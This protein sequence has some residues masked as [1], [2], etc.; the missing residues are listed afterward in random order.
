L[1]P[2]AERAT[3]EEVTV[4][5]QLQD[6]PG[7]ETRLREALLAEHRCIDS[8]LEDILR[9]ELDDGPDGVL[10]D[11]WRRCASL[12][13]LHLE[14]EESLLFPIYESHEPRQARLLRDDHARIRLLV[15]DVGLAFDM[16]SS[17]QAS[18]VILQSALQKHT[19]HEEATIYRY[20]T[21]EAPF[22][23]WD[24]VRTILNARR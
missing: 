13:R 8:I 21:R 18:L 16:P 6:G 24:R 2:S 9:G 3:R 19:K 1:Q 4:Q 5:E 7:A 22:P 15:A 11:E 20:A 12:I 23:L 10:S 14:I 17:R